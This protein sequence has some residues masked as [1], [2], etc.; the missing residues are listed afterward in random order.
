MSPMEVAW[1][2]PVGQMSS[3][4]PSTDP[5]ASPRQAL[6]RVIRLSLERPP[7]GVAF[8]GGRDSSTALA[9]ATYVARRDGLPEPVPITKV[10]PDVAEAEERDWQELVVRHLGLNDWQRIVI[11]DELD[12]V[13]TLAA[14]HLVRYGV[15]WP[16]TIAGDVPV[17]DAVR[18]DGDRR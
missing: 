9:I 15:L 3:L 17:V 4:P 14:E 11:D 12:V 2:Y 8:S 18:G 13:G 5:T 7:C 10:F 6:E 16:P 1:G